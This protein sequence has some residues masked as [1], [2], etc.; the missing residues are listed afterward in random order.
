VVAQVRAGLAKGNNFGVGRGV[1]VGEIAVPAPT[2]DLAGMNHDRSHGNLA[3]FQGALGG[4]ESFLH[5]KLVRDWGWLLAVGHWSLV[6]VTGV[7][8]KPL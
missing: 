6:M 2:D 4:A 7:R 3:C 8:A 1:G 5:P